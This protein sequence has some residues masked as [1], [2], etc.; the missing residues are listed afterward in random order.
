MGI[1]YACFVNNKSE[2]EFQCW[3]R[4]KVSNDK[5]DRKWQKN[6]RNWL[7]MTKWQKMAKNDKVTKMTGFD[8]NDIIGM[9]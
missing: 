7:K 2:N 8:M 4:V 5:N 9:I 1:P 6:D 3:P